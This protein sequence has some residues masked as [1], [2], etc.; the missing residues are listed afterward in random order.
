MFSTQ[1]NVI[2]RLEG[3]D[4]AGRAGQ[5]ISAIKGGEGTLCMEG[6]VGSKLSGVEVAKQW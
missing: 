4:E 1:G 2:V 5:P 6:L 3:C